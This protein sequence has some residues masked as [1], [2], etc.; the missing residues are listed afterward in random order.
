M[1]RYY[2]YHLLISIGARRL[3]VTAK[4]CQSVLV[5]LKLLVRFLLFWIALRQGGILA[6]SFSNRLVS[7]RRADKASVIIILDLG[8]LKR[9]FRKFHSLGSDVGHLNGD[10]A[11]SSLNLS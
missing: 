11:L 3:R 9:L 10:L 6:F 5:L 4:S 7:C 2:L 1:Y 8:K